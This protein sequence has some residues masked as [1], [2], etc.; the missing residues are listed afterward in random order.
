MKVYLQI[1]LA[2]DGVVFQYTH[3]QVNLKEIEIH[4][5]TPTD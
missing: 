4:L 5:T 2:Y 3:H 1:S